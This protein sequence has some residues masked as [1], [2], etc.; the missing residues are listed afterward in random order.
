MR[1]AI[2]DISFADRQINSLLYSNFVYNCHEFD[3]FFYFN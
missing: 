2:S 1:Q 3:E